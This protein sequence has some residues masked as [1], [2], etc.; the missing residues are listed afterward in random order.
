MKIFS[1]FVLLFCVV[2]VVEAANLHQINVFDKQAFTRVEILLDSKVRYKTLVLDNPP[3]IV[4]DLVGTVNTRPQFPVKSERIKQIRHA[5]RDRKNY[6]L[7]FDLFKREKF[8]HY[9]SSEKSGKQRLIVELGNWQDAAIDPGT[10]ILRDVIVVIDPG[11]GDKDPGAVG[12]FKVKGKPG[13][14]NVLEKDIVL[15]VSKLL[16]T[17]LNKIPGITVRL[18]REDDS[19]IALRERIR[20]SQEYNADLFLSLHADALKQKTV[21]GSSVYVLSE[22]A[23]TS[24]MARWLAES[25]NAP[26]SVAGVDLNNKDKEVVVILADLS[27]TA[28]LQSS[29]DFAR[30]MLQVLNSG[31]QLRTKNI[32]AA[33]F[34]VLKSLDVPSIL[35]ELG[36]LSNPQEVKK[37]KNQSYQNS[38]AGLLMQGIKQYLQANPIPETVFTLK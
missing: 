22:N 6:R 32:E 27:Q 26:W 34:A 2:S 14:S 15:A 8:R 35:V 10:P 30:I 19:F 16:Q 36:Y 21:S 23:A 4:I 20:I 24:E 11:H 17:K 1:Y 31:V 29:L 13:M 37:L 9:F 7:V 3:R 33:D 28:T 18:T 25:H 5:V 12:K 38:I